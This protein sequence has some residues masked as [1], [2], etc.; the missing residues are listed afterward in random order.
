M[1]DDAL[2]TDL[3]KGERPRTSVHVFS[4]TPRRL[5][6]GDQHTQDVGLAPPLG[7]H[8]AKGALQLAYVRSIGVLLPRLALHKHRQGR[9]VAQTRQ[10][11]VADEVYP[12]VVLAAGAQQREAQT[13]QRRGG[14]VFVGGADVHGGCGRKACALGVGEEGGERVVVRRARGD[15]EPGDIDGRGTDGRSGD[16][17]AGR[18]GEV[19]F[20]C[21][22]AGEM[23]LRAGEETHYKQM[24]RA[25]CAPG[26]IFIRNKAGASERREGNKGK[27]RGNWR[28]GA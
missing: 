25:V 14:Y 27:D 26:N 8:A 6:L 12:R 2:A 4:H 19:V 9:A 24:W 1:C 11:P 10:H 28:A 7:R 16:N 20:R 21:G 18:A 23:C 5:L 15:E 13:T 22:C 3:E 17:A